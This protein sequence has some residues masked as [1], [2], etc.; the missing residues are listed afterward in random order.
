MMR[1]SVIGF[2]ILCFLRLAIAQD[3]QKN[4]DLRPGGQIL[5]GNFLGNI[6]VTGYSGSSV[7]VKAYTKGANRQAIRIND[8]SFGNRIELAPL[9]PPFYNST[10]TVN[11]EVR[12]PDSIPFNFDRLSSFSGTVVVS[13]VVGRLRADSQRGNVEV[14]DV[15]GLVSATSVS[16][17]VVVEITRAQDPSTMRFRSISGNV[18]VSAP[19]NLYAFIQM[20]SESGLLKT[21][22][23]IDVQERRYGPGREA[24]GK[25]GSGKQRLWINSNSGRVSL[26]QKQEKPS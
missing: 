8:L 26:L 6:T 17:D 3:F 11:F 22:F 10:A 25:L 9:Y 1:K 13:N 19:S 18:A 20:S 14:K 21:D 23:P 12:V 15:R 4:Y 7:E 16:G 24:R 5:I 2:A